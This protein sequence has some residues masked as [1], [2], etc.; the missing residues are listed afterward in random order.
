MP[1]LMGALCG[2]R[3]VTREKMVEADSQTLSS[4]VRLESLVERSL[5]LWKWR[6]SVEERSLIPRYSRGTT[7]PD[8]T[9]TFPDPQL[10]PGSEEF[11]CPLLDICYKSKLCLHVTD[12]NTSY[13]N[14]VKTINGLRLL[15]RAASVWMDRLGGQSPQ[16]KTLYK[17]SHKKKRLETFSGESCMVPSPQIILPLF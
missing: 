10:S 11:S 5:E 12:K 15:N 7:K 17:T 8:P 14:I 2:S 1:K 16:W 13:L 9:D 6:L 4:M 3:T